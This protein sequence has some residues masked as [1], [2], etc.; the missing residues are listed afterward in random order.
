MRDYAQK[1]LAMVEGQTREDLDRDEKLRLALT[2]LVELVREAASQVPAGVRK[3]YPEVPWT[4]AIA[5]RH[6]LVHGYDF[7]L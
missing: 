1:A 6:R 3:G 7:G 4:K 2:H 5:M